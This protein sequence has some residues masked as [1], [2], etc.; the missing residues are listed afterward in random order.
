MKK[1]NS[2]KIKIRKNYINCPEC[3]GTGYKYIPSKKYSSSWNDFNSEY[4]CI[5]CNGMKK[6]EI[7]Y[8]K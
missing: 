4:K 5:L 2:L 7:I 8:E 1:Y 6:L 3:E